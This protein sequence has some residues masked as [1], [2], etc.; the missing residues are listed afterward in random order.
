[1]SS[2]SII[3][4]RA[5]LIAS[6]H[7]IAGCFATGDELDRLDE[8][9]SDNGEVAV[10]AQAL[11]ATGYGSVA[12]EELDG[13]TLAE[14][15]SNLHHL[16]GRDIALVLH[17]K[18]ENI[19]DP[20]RWDVV[21]DAVSR[22]I[23]VQ[24]WLTLPESLGY[25]PNAT[26][27]S[28]W[29]T[30]AQYLMFLWRSR[31]LPSTSFVVDM[32]MSKSKLH[33][34]QEL[35]AAGDPFAVARFLNGNINRSQFAA[36]TTAYRGFVDYAHLLGF[37][38]TV[39]TLL[40]LLEDYGDGDDFIRQGFNSPIDGIAWDEVSFQVHRTLYGA[41]YP[42]TS[43]MVYEYGRLARNRFGARAGLGLGLTHPGIDVGNQAIVYSSGH[44]LRLDAQAAKAAGFSPSRVGVYSFLGIYRS[45]DVGQWFQVPGS[46]RPLP[47]FGT[48]LL[49]ASIQAL[50]SLDWVR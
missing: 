22:G 43:Y 10:S 4:V 24:P 44:Q 36:A 19:D 8:L 30:H 9:D 20:A 49:R 25:F 17:W 26:N 15:K 3:A 45:D 2:K 29:I 5:F 28:T 38:V 13:A 27:Y 31:G 46:S 6:L 47:D 41:S 48:G 50:D 16:A 14:L 32:E 35:T 40:P 39:T 7:V 12:W 1:M 18:A 11:S 21:H 23:P 37:K 34:F 42:L 33:R